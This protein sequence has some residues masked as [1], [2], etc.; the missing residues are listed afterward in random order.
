MCYLY[1]APT[2]VISTPHS[3]VALDNIA[4]VV[5]RNYNATTVSDNRISLHNNYI[6]DSQFR[7]VAER[8]RVITANA[9]N[10]FCGRRA[11]ECTAVIPAS[12]R[13]Q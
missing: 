6:F 2:L 9:I 3:S 7:N 1:V 10:D 8:F 12:R 5:L 13:R 11:E 4:T